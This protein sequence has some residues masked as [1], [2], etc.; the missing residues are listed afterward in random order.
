MRGNHDGVDSRTERIDVKSKHEWS[1]EFG[2][3]KTIL[4][5][6]ETMSAKIMPEEVKR[7]QKDAMEEAAA[8]VAHS[9]LVGEAV[10]NIY[11]RIDKL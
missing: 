4:G 1:K 10:K 7:I 2:T 8:I 3:I 6:V 9:G 11:K 5:G